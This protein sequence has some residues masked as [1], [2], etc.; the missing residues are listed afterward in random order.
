MPRFHNNAN[1]F[2]CY[3]S[4]SEKEEYAVKWVN[5]RE[6]QSGIVDI[7]SLHGGQGYR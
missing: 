1:T 6:A 7:E 2:F 5:E 3:C 4:C